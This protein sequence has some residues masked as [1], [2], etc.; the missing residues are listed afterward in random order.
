ME[1]LNR[2]S[3]LHTAEEECPLPLQKYIS[4]ILV[5]FHLQHSMDGACIPFPLIWMWSW[6]EIWMSGNEWMNGSTIE[7]FWIVVMGY[8]KNDFYQK[9][10]CGW[11]SFVFLTNILLFP[12]KKQIFFPYHIVYLNTLSNWWHLFYCKIPNPVNKA[13]YAWWNEK[14]HNFGMMKT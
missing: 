8:V 4:L 13:L 5:H 6:D 9:T 7:M 12:K 1:G 14:Y 3:I 2:N 10:T 11:M